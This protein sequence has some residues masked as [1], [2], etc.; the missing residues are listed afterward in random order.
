VGVARSGQFARIFIRRVETHFMLPA[1]LTPGAGQKGQRRWMSMRG[2]GLQISVL[3]LSLF[4][5]QEG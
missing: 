3:C 5:G 2:G 1:K 4:Y